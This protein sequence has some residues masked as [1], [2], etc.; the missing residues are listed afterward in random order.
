MA[1]IECRCGTTI[2]V[3]ESIAD[4]V[5]PSQYADLCPSCINDELGIDNLARN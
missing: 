3:T 2:T 5:M 1:Q 4:G